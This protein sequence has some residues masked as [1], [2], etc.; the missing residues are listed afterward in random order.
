[1]ET[2]KETILSRIPKLTRKKALIAI[3]ILL[4]L[5]VALLVSIN[6]AKSGTLEAMTL[7]SQD[8]EEKIVAVGLLQLEQE[9]SLTAEVSGVVEVVNGKEG[10]L[11]PAGSVIIQIDDKDQ[12]FS[13]EEKQASYLDA[14]AQYSHLVEF[15]YQAAKEELNRLTSVKD[16]AKKTYDDAKQLYEEGAISQSAYT[17]QKLNYE[18]ALAQWNTAKLNLQA[19]SEGGALRSGAQSR[20]QSAKATYERALDSNS[21]YQITVPWD[22]VLLQSYVEPQ[23]YVQAGQVLADIGQQ[24]GYYV[25]T[26]LDEKYF[27]YIRVGLPALISIGE[28][29]VGMV[30]GNIDI[31]SRKIDETTG[32]FKVRIAMP[33]E[34]PF[35]A[36]NL[37]VNIELLLQSKQNALVVPNEYLLYGE[38]TSVFLY[39]NGKA[40]LTPVEVS[41]G[42]SAKAVITKGLEDGDVLIKPV[43]DLQDGDQVKISKG[44]AS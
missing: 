36:S 1:M 12:G 6:V 18:A 14:E 44:D 27:P 38:D 43:S 30:E 41:V 23:D 31:V 34:F 5:I 17:E 2:I 8:Y 19:L 7:A 16:Q 10:D 26:E 37:T 42:P 21:N 28:D 29:R 20:V 25:N 32:T 3:L 40:V 39:Q 24:G 33:E 11:F 13:L 35:Q 4:I 22:S 15:D 9:T